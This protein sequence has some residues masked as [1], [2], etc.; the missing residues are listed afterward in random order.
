MHVDTSYF[1]LFDVRVLAGRGFAAADAALPARAR[2]VI[3]N[4]SFV[5]EVLGGGDP[6]GRRV[7]Y[8]S[9]DGEVNPWHVV[10]GVVEDFP[11][12]LPEPGETS[13][14][15]MFHLAA[16]GEFGGDALLTIRLRA[17]T[18][19]AF[20]PTL[21]RIA[22]SVDPMLQLSPPQ[23]LHSR[24]REDARTGARVALV[25]AL[26]TGSVLLLSAAGIHAL[27]SFTVNQRR[28]EIGI[29]AALGAPA[30][31]ILTSVLTR[32]TRQL[33]LGVGIGL[34]A[35]VALDQASGGVLL[36]GSGVLLVPATA[37]FMLVVGLVAAAGPARRGLRVQP[38]EALRAE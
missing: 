31:R 24:Y 34:A 6:V 28:R 21:R 2:P 35:A 30:R 15:R 22:I 25:I 12:G 13:S 20:V 7:R 38:T 8:R 27:M 37:A 19:E 16:P 9:Y 18:P 32:A 14:A 5:T 1:G 11:V 10:V 4:R 26:I 23:S 29:R 17:Q 3:V 33:A 36:D